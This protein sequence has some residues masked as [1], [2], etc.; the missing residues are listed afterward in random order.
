VDINRY[1]DM[2]SASLLVIPTFS[3]PRIPFLTRALSYFRS[4]TDRNDELC[5]LRWVFLSSQLIPD[6]QVEDN[7]M[8]AFSLS[9]IMTG[10]CHG[11]TLLII[12]SQNSG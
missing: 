11:P 12:R 10:Q 7:G 8:M 2:A 1:P 5:F 3:G 9:R 6:E 4:R